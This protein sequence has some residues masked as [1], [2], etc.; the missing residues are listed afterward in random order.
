M[1]GSTKSGLGR[2]LAA[3]IPTAERSEEASLSGPERILHSLAH[4][5]LAQL[6][7][8]AGIELSISAYLHL[9]RYDEP[10]LFLRR[11]TF[12]TLTPTRA[13]RLFTRM[14]D[15]VRSNASEGTF[16]FDDLVG[17]YVRT[18]GTVS[19]GLHVVARRGAVIAQGALASAR[20]TCQTFATVTNQ[21]AAGTPADLPSPRL[22]IETGGE[23]ATVEVSFVE[24]DR[25]HTGRGTADD[26][27]RA[28][29]QAVLEAAGSPLTL[30]TVREMTVDTERGV[31]VL[32]SDRGRPC[33][34]FVVGDDDLAQLTAVATLRALTG[35]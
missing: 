2:G 16:L 6:D 34:G 7:D 17:V 23:Q 33:P 24:N 32:L 14:A 25:T 18:P 27:P 10:T 29:A 19:D 13:F 12:D 4:T 30:R 22:V 3:L 8:A 35:R 31:L 21:Y 9:P 28:V 26:A 20:A 11:P 5:G 15:I 1:I